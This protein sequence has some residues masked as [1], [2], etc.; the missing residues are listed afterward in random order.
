MTT[1]RAF[2]LATDELYKEWA[3]VAMSRGRLDNK[4]YT[5]VDD[6]PLAEELD[7]PREP[8]PDAVLAVTAALELSRAQY[9]A[10]DQLTATGGGGS[11]PPSHSEIHRDVGPSTAPPPPATSPAT[12]PQEDLARLRVLPRACSIELLHAREQ[13]AAQRPGWHQR[14]LLNKT[15]AS[16]QRTLDDLDQQI[17]RLEARPPQIATSEGGPAT[18]GGAHAAA[19][20]TPIEHDPPRYLVAELGGWPHTQAAQTVWR[21]AASRIRAYRSSAG[22]TDPKTALGPPPDDPNEYGQQQAV[23]EFIRSAGKAI[24]VLESPVRPDPT[25]LAFFELP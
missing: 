17:A 11:T 22:V 2:V 19:E 15:I 18:S 25:N 10:L 4:L 12:D 20:P 5:T 24:D 16:R 14:R 21:I 3:Y 1:D 6:H 7:V 13:L 9:L 23:A 8:K